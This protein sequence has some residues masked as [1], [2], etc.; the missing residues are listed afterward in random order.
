M[1]DPN[2]TTEPNHPASIFD[3]D[4]PCPRCGYNVRGLTEPRCPECGAGFDPRQA[5]DCLQRRKLNPPSWRIIR[6]VLRHPICVWSSP[7]VLHGW[8]ATLGQQAAIPAI[9]LGVPV[10][11]LILLSLIMS[12]QGYGSVLG[13][14]VGWAIAWAIG[15]ALALGAGLLHRVLCW[16]GLRVGGMLERSEDAG[17]VIGYA[18]DWLVPTIPCAI[19]GVGIAS[20]IIARRSYAGSVPAPG[21]S[22]YVAAGLFAMGLLVLLCLWSL[23]LYRAM[24]VAARISPVLAA[25]CALSNPFLW[26]FALLELQILVALVV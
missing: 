2:E 10:L 23:A 21:T 22:S 6:N 19:A 26:L 16:L 17:I 11:C 3:E 4:V 18:T 1:D 5:L 20:G 24:R 12:P 8:G 13:D 14:S 15:T 9:G 7:E 25:W